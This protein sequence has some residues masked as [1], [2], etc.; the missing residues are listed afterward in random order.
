MDAAGTG[1]AAA[2]WLTRCGSD[3]RLPAGVAR[4]EGLACLFS[5]DL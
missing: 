1:C 3:A 5:Y 2:S 4:G